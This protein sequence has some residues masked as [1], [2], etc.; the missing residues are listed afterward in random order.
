MLYLWEIGH[1]TEFFGNFVA[2]VQRAAVSFGR[3]AGLMQGAPALA[4]VAPRP[5]D[6]DV[7]HIPTPLEPRVRQTSDTLARL[8]VQGLC[9]LH[10]DSGRG[11]ETASFSIIKGEF[12]VITGRIGSGK[13]TLVRSILGLLPKQSGVVTWNG[14]TV[15][16]LAEFMQPPRSAYTPQV[17]TLLSGTVLENIQLG[18][19]S[20][21]IEA[22]TRQAVLESDLEQLPKHLETL[23]GV[24]G[25][26]LSG[27]QLQRAAAARMF[28]QDAALLVLDDISSALDVKTEETLWERLKNTDKTCLVVSHRRPALQRAD[29]II[30]LEHG[31]VADVGS[32]EELLARSAEMRRLWAGEVE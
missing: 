3:M 11:L 14:E 12:V 16:D 31:R 5:T 24:R 22:A 10:P 28:A 15:Q 25:L 6:L 19:D 17:P 9:Y 7:R 13:T 18:A 2:T 8:E 29:K 23:V 20:S 21:H 26:K 32:L 1:H 4:L 27:G 30:L